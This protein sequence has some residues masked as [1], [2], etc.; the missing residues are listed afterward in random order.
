M[1]VNGASKVLEKRIAIDG[2]VYVIKSDD[3]YL[4]NVGD[5]FEPA[6][7]DLFKAFIAEED[8]VFDVGANI[9][10]T[11]ILFSGLSSRVFSFEPSPSTF[12]LFAEN[13]NNAGARN[14]VPCNVGLGSSAGSSTITFSSNNRSG[15][16]VSER[17]QPGE[18]HITEDIEILTLDD[19]CRDRDVSPD[20]I[21]IDVEGF[22]KSVI[23][24][25]L[26]TIDRCKPIVIAEMNSFC[27]N[28][29]HRTSLPDFI[30]FMKSVFPRLYAVDVNNAAFED[31]HDPRRAYLVMHQNVVRHRFPNLVGGFD[32]SV[33]GTLERLAA[34][35]AERQSRHLLERSFATPK[36]EKFEGSIRAV[37]TPGEMRANEVRD[38]PVK[39]VNGTDC[40]WIGY[41]SNP[42]RLS[43]HWAGG[44]EKPIVNGLR[45]LI[46]GKKI[47]A[48]TEHMQS[49][50]IAAPPA[51]GTYQLTLTLVQEGVAWFEKRGFDC[52]TIELAVRA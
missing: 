15:G 50:R 40:D 51:P 17:I 2:K 24:G 33:A 41:G 16:F 11:S 20:F 29:L 39:I 30:D 32:D 3:V 8:I 46:D 13:L 23:E 38:L 14:V 27:L 44:G 48:G 49:I 18:G 21:K 22:E 9:G 19:F 35:E 25:G 52:E 12:A 6:M 42:V 26:A 1:S 47:A 37:E 5:E 34:N 45:T 36:L 31:L 4:K 10:L 43:Y 7:V 28:V